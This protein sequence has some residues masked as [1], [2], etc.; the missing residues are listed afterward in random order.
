LLKED[1][2]N[3]CRSAPVKW[4]ASIEQWTSSRPPRLLAPGFLTPLGKGA[5][6]IFAYDE[7][8]QGSLFG[9]IHLD[10]A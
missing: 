2:E 4:T 7:I 8:V 9:L 3:F 6:N 1:S 5:V 10:L